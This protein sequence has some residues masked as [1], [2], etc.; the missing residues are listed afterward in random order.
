[1]E[2]FILEDTQA[3]TRESR[4][5]NNSN[6]IENEESTIYDI[7]NSLTESVDDNNY[8]FKFTISNHRKTSL[9][10]LNRILKTKITNYYK[11]IR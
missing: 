7:I 3:L 9:L 10:F 8:S 5:G 2:Q 1:M 11:A 4:Y 6:R